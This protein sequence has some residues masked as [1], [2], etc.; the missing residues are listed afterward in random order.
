MEE[1]CSAV[2]LKISIAFEDAF[3]ELVGVD[4]TVCINVFETDEFGDIELFLTLSG[5]ATIMFSSAS[6]NSVELL[7]AD[8]NLFTP[9]F[10]VVSLLLG[11]L[12]T[13]SGELSSIVESLVEPSSL[14][15]LSCKYPISSSDEFGCFI[16]L[17]EPKST[18]SL[19]FDALRLTIC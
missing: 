12:S 6:K 19:L 15:I 18:F 13:L 1:N 8:S 14:F 3:L 4:N 10:G 16:S 2:L 7:F 11:A 17:F 5:I 9:F